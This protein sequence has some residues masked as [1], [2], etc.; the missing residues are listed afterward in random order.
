[1]V[2]SVKGTHAMEGLFSDAE[3]NAI[4]ARYVSG[5]FDMEQF[6]N[7]MDAH[8]LSLVSRISLLSSVA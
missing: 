7:A 2:E 1:M 8:A 3:T 6:S 4:F 5:E